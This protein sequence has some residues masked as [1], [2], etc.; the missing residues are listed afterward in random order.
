LTLPRPGR[1]GAVRLA[2]V[3]QVM[4][5]L[6]P[7]TCRP[8]VLAV[9]V[10]ALCGGCRAPHEGE[11]L[12]V[13]EALA[14]LSS[15]VQGPAGPLTVEACVD[16]ALAN[17]RRIRVADRR[18]LIAQDRQSEAIASILPQIVSDVRWQTR[19]N[20]PGFLA[21]GFAGPAGDRTVTT[22]SVSLLVPIYD[23]GRAS[24]TLEGLR[25]S[26]DVAD[27]AARRTR[28]DVE[29]AV[30]VTYGRL[31]E[32]QAI[33]GVVDDSIRL[34]ER[35]LVVAKDR[36]AQGIVSRL[37]VLSLETQLAARRQERIRAGNN[38]ELARATL[39]RQ[40]GLDVNGPLEIV[41][42][43]EADAWNGPF[44]DLL[45]LAF[46]RRTDL[47][48]QRKA[49]ALA[50]AE[51]RVTNAGHFPRVYGF[52]RFDTTTDS[53]VLN[54]EW[55]TGGVG[56]QIPILEGGKTRAELKRKEREIDEA[57]DLHAEL[58]DDVVLGVK[59]A[60][61]DLR[62]AQ[63]LLP[64]ARMGIEQAEE[65]VRVAA[66]QY[67]QGMI[68]SADLLAEEERLATARSSFV[69]SRYALH[70]AYARLVHEIG[71]TPR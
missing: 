43:P 61:L 45:R 44:V 24:N 36:H 59:K 8:A 56:V 15:P 40:M 22:T 12:Y 51:Y 48:A 33:R 2:P 60:W 30:R 70:E 16:L 57:L 58:S 71:G 53:F 5:R 49:V 28:E 41:D 47:E 29:L 26:E 54:P 11:P 50:Q 21:G 32:A 6:S 19:D 4:I 23:F 14:E 9:L 35:Q 31:L 42:V 38:V 65:S 7:S 64:V 20:D 66:E 17:S 62:A 25:L 55:L 69:R 27:L 52:G 1:I 34:L 68:A 39:N 18:I 63:E 13:P 3:L 10:V 46:E 37:D 67:A